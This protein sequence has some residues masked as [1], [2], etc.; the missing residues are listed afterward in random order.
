SQQEHLRTAAKNMKPWTI[1]PACALAC[2]VA[3]A[4][5][6]RAQQPTPQAPAS[7]S[8]DKRWPG[9][10]PPAAPGGAA[11][12]PKPGGARAKPAPQGQDAVAA[13]AIKP[14]P[15]PARVIACSG[16]FAKDSSH[17]KLATFFGADNITW[18][19]V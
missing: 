8:L 18:A 12:A 1:A 10:E 16:V 5:A 7:S 15:A 14:Q 17:L 3:L 19:K 11:P 6:A 4:S 9:G 13:P 2:V